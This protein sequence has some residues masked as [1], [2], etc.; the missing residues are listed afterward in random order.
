MARP[1]ISKTE[2]FEK[3]NQLIGEGIEPTI[4]QVRLKLGTGSNSTIAGYLREWRALQN[5]NDGSALNEDLPHEFIGLMKGLWQRLLHQTN[6]K[7]AAIQQGVEETVSSLKEELNALK[8][9]NARIEQQ[10]EKIKQEKNS[11]I[12]DKL[13]LELIVSQKDQEITSLS[14]DNHGFSVQLTEKQSYIDELQRL[15]KQAQEN[16]E[17]YREQ[18][19]EQRILENERHA[20]AQQQLEMTI[21]EV[22]Q[23]LVLASQ[24]KAKLQRDSDKMMQEKEFLQKAYDTMAGKFNKL[25][26]NFI[27][28]EKEQEENLHNFKSQQ[29]Q[30]ELL[31]KKMEEQSMMLIEFQKQIAVLSQQLADSRTEMSDLKEQNKLLGH[32]KWELIQEKA[33][34]MG[35]MKQ[36][37]T[38]IH[39]KL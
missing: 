25:Q 21:K 31:Q 6:N 18:T 9:E 35:Q 19:R 34:L 7:V 37:Q 16:L 1:G 13:T 14:S 36:M 24:D 23:T 32:E 12:G 15:H 11:L 39:P 26:L 10:Y 5:K 3:A 30:Y 33:Q 20:R 2:V 27:K 28:L 17:H 8:Q 22:Q 38:I 29:Q 4:E